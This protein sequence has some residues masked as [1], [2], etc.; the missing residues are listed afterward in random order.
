MI[1]GNV[2]LEKI[3]NIKLNE[4]NFT[5]DGRVLDLYESVF[6]P[7]PQS[8]AF[9]FSLSTDLTYSAFV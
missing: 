2:S 7:S 5:A 9:H 3:F 1:L 6:Y 8:E 4:G